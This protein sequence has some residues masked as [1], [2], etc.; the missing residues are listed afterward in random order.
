MGVP[1]TCVGA[2]LTVLSDRRKT[3]SDPS[4]VSKRSDFV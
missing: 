2:V 1:F 3:Y 4:A